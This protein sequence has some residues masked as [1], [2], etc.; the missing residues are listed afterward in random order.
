MQRMGIASVLTDNLWINY[1]IVKDAK[2]N[3]IPCFFFLFKLKQLAEVSLFFFS[4][5]FSL[6]I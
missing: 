3:P 4:L 2:S 1:G 5:S 6:Q